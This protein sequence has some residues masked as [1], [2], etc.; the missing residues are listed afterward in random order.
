[1]ILKQGIYKITNKVDG[2]FYYGSA[3]KNFKIRWSDHINDLKAKRHGNRLMQDAWN[4]YGEG[5]FKFEIIEIIERGNLTKK[6]FKKILLAKEQN[7]IDKYFDGGSFCYN[8]CPNANNALGTK[9]TEES[10]RNISIGRAGKGLS[11]TNKLGKKESKAT[12]LRKS[13]WHKGRP[14]SLEHRKSISN[15]Q[16][17][18]KH[19]KETREKMRRAKIGKKNSIESRKKQS[20]SN[21]G[22]NNPMYGRKHSKETKRKISKA[23]KKS[24]KEKK[25]ERK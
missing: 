20:K 13:I 7:Y 2:K 12:R 19:S 5:C 16:L 14:L 3:S 17:G 25:N 18:R 10:R 9:R 8:L 1:M 21:M 22:K 15:G 6:R 11:N 24:N 4:K 23:L